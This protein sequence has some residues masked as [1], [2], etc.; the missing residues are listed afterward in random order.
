M[1]AGDPGNYS[2][3]PDELDEIIVELEKTES[4]LELLIADL[5]KQMATLQSTWDG[6]AAQA[7]AEAHE[8]WTAGMNAMRTAMA[9]LRAAARVAHGNYH[10]A[11]HANRTMWNQVR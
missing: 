9:E 3:D 11:V 6:L 5:T 10:G 2:V 8:E 1:G 7:Q 4:A